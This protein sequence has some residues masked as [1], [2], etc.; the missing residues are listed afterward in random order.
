MKVEM[1]M[2]KLLDVRRK[3][4]VRIAVPGAPPEK[5]YLPESKFPETKQSSTSMRQGTRV[6]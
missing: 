1:L 6:P 3:H 2:Q 4:V 5:L